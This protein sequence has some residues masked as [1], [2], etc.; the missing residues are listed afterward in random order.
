LLVSLIIF[1]F[2]PYKLVAVLVAVGP[3]QKSLEM[4]KNIEPKYGNPI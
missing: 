1:I 2:N 4:L 3:E